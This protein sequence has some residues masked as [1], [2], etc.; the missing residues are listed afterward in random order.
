MASLETIMTQGDG[1]SPAVTPALQAFA[2]MINSGGWRRPGGPLGALIYQ[3]PWDDATV[4]TLAVYSETAVIAERANPEGKPVWRWRGTL[5]D[6]LPALQ[7]LPPPSD[8][9]AP[10]QVLDHNDAPNHRWT[11]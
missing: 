9:T 5:A 4:D 6:V 3:Y 8:P 1:P 10:R 2:D 11:P 7:A